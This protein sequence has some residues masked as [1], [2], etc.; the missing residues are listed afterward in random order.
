[1]DDLSL[2]MLKHNMTL[3]IIQYVR[4]YNRC[5]GT[6]LFGTLSETEQNAV[7]T[8]EDTLKVLESLCME[9]YEIEEEDASI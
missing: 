5:A 7:V 4:N 3:N 1:M 6:G 9:Y 2:T 8:L